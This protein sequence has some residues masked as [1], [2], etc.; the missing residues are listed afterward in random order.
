MSTDFLQLQNRHTGEILRMRRAR[1]A[2]GRAILNLDGSL[3]PGASGPPLHVHFQE[4]EEGNVKAGTLYAQVG[5]DK[6]V[7]PR[8]DGAVF[9]AGTPHAWWN[10]GGDLLEFSGC[11]VP[12]IDL[13]RYLQG[14]FAVLNAGT[15]GRPPIFYLAHVLWRHRRTQALMTPPPAVQRIIFPAVLFIGRILGKYKGTS[16]PGSPE[17]CTGAPEVT[18]ANA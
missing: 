14:V 9:P 12:A 2:E 15:P 18:A 13:D 16:W 3:P 7:V 6:I 10:G 4:R 5:K 1:D 11:V 8:G 17:S